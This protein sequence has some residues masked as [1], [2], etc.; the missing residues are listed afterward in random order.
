ML[1]VM[2]LWSDNEFMMNSKLPDC[3]GDYSSLIAEGVDSSF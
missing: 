2:Y 1:P 3:E